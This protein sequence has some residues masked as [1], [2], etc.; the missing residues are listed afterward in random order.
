VTASQENRETPWIEIPAILGLDCGERAKRTA[1][2]RE[3]YVTTRFTE[4]TSSFWRELGRKTWMGQRSILIGRMSN[5]TRSFGVMETWSTT[6][7]AYTDL[8]HMQ[9]WGRRGILPRIVFNH[10]IKR[11]DWMDVLGSISGKYGR[12]IRA[13]LGEGLGDNKWGLL[14]RNYYPQ[15]WTKSYGNIL[16]FNSNRT[17]QKAML[18]FYKVCNCSS[19]TT[20][21]L[22]GASLFHPDL[23][24]MRRF[25][26]IWRIIFRALPQ[27]FHSLYK[28]LRVTIQGSLE[29]IT[30]ERI[31]ELCT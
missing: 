4:E 26:M 8:D 29:S 12:R 7:E 15:L 16:S 3:G 13:F 9:N 31:K 25:G 28:R 17:M 22:N 20:E 14:F 6:W 27:K 23:S 1:F 11:E 5:G 19:R 24:P 21:L 10:A 30:Y 18:C 2:K